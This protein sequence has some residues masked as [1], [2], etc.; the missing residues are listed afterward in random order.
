MKTIEDLKAIFESIVEAVIN[1]EHDI[2]DGIWTENTVCFEQD[3]WSTEI[4]YEC[5]GKF[6]HSK[7]DWWTPGDCDLIN[8]KGKITS[9]E[10]VAYIDPETGEETD[11]EDEDLNELKA[12]LNKELE[13]IF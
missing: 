13:C 11:F 6:S 7:G 3:G 1:N 4:E 8:A 9:L 10:C 5:Y 2:Q 12:L